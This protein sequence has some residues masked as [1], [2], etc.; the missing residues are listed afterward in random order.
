MTSVAICF[1]I[2][3]RKITVFYSPFE[4]VSKQHGRLLITYNVR[5]SYDICATQHYDV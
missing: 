3:Q 1:V 4:K 5:F 2:L